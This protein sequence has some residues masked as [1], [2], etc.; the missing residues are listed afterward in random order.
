MKRWMLSVA[1]WLLLRLRYPFIGRFAW[2]PRWA[3]K[4]HLVPFAWT[5]RIARKLEAMEEKTC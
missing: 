4:I 1:D 5:D 3:L 2:T